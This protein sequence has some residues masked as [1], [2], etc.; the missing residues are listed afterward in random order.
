MCLVPCAL[1]VLLPASLQSSHRRHFT[2]YRHRATAPTFQA[3]DSPLPYGQAP[4]PPLVAEEEAAL[5]EDDWYVHAP[6]SEAGGGAG[7]GGGGTTQGPLTREE[8]VRAGHEEEGNGGGLMVWH[9]T[10]TPA[11]TPWSEVSGVCGGRERGAL[12]A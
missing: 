3:M 2:Y 6:E 8:A 10:A 5:A 9:P 7:S 12:P 11:W 1:F 4:P